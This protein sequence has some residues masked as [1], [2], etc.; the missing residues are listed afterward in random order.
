MSVD[1]AAPTASA[2]GSASRTRPIGRALRI[3]VIHHRREE[4]RDGSGHL[5]GDFCALWS[6]DG[7]EIVHVRGPDRFVPADIAIVH[8]DLSVVPAAYLALARRYPAAINAGIADIRK[9][10]V[11]AARLLPMSGPVVVKSNLNH[12]GLP[13]IGR[14]GRIGSLGRRA[15]R[16]I[17]R[18]LAGLATDYAVFPSLAAV[19]AILRYHPG[20][21]VEPFIPERHGGG[22]VLRQSYFLGDRAISWFEPGS[23]P[24]IHS[25][26]DED[27]FEIPTPPEV[28]AARRAFGLDYGKIDYVEFEGRPVILDVAKTI[29]ERGSTP[30]TVARLAPGI[31]AYAAARGPLAPPPAAIDTPCGP[32]AP[33]EMPKEAP[34]RPLRSTLPAD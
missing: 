14:S 26:R 12:R 5:I 19:P 18:R 16:A 25:S 10:R 7:H 28:H 4:P 24:F 23:G 29:G 31:A 9:R 33:L 22:F 8:V 34:T 6:A 2:S 11:S 13:E 15:A 30:A 27:D 20:F 3:V 17:T 1:Q 32:V 21:V